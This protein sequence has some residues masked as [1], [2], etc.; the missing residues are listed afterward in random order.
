MRYLVAVA[1]LLA[2]LLALVIYAAF[3][4]GDGSTRIAVPETSSSAAPTTGESTTSG[5]T[6]TVAP[7]DTGE[8]T[9]GTLAFTVHGIEIA[10]SIAAA[11]VPVRKT[12]RGEYVIVHM[13]VRN[14]GDAPAT[15]L[16]TFQKL[17]AAGTNYPID[18]EA[19]FYAGGGIAQLAPGDEADVAVAFDVP[20]GTSPDAIELHA[21]PL[22]PGIEVPLT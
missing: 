17:A 2:V 11:D 20:P 12:A 1:A 13:T 21:D 9:D 15:F 10:P 18:D 6:E 8:V 7:P 5:D 4:T 3:F 22:S 16:G 14:I 19:T